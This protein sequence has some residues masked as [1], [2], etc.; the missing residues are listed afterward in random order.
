MAESSKENHHVYFSTQL[1]QIRWQRSRRGRKPEH[2]PIM[3]AKAGLFAQD[4]NDR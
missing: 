1:S 2:V 4:A 3:D